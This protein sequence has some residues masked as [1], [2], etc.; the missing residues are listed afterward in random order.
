MKAARFYKPKE[1]LKIEEIPTPSIQ[2]DE[3]LVKV[4]ATGICG[5]DIH[6]VF[7]DDNPTAFSPIT[8]GHESSG[9]VVKVGE[10]VK[11]WSVGERASVVPIVSC[12]EC[13]YCLS[14]QSEICENR[15][16]IG[17][18]RNGALA[19]Y[20]AV[21]AK[22]LVRL[23]DEVSFEEGAIITD[24]IA[25]PYK[26]II[27][28]AQLKGGESIAIF[29]A[30]GL[31]LHA[32]QI[33]K[34]AGAKVIIVVDV[35]DEQLSRAK[36]LGATFTINSTRESVV[37]KIRELTGGRGV[38]VAAEL[39]GLQVT[40]SQAV[41]SLKSGG[42]AVIVGLGSENIQLIPPAIFIRKQ[43][44]LL[45]SYGFTKQTIEKLVELVATGK[46]NVKESITHRFSLEEVNT[47]LRYLNEKIENP[48]R[49]V[50]TYP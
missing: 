43:L 31:G 17:L 7:G 50:I 27:D 13:E 1:L 33:A 34:L 15:E 35:R 26:M 41:E 32:V 28:R 20:V 23:P 22:N 19:E 10:E 11:G 36:A 12:G 40:I 42:R 45:G 16:V 3:V 14:H 9:V 47:A 25:T 30:G 2:N 6:A 29:G 21:P 24:A 8:L 4:K 49:I 5:T 48:I 37:E 39:V 38:D 18:Q 44:S 46:L